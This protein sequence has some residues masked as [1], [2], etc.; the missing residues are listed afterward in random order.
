MSL[1][2]LKASYDDPSLVNEI[3]DSL[4]MEFPDVKVGDVVYY[5]SG[6]FNYQYFIQLTTKYLP[7]GAHFE[8]TTDGSRGSIEF[9]LEAQ[10]EEE[11]FKRLKRIGVR[12]MH[13]LEN[14]PVTCEQ[15]GKLPFGNF[16]VNHGGISNM[17]DFVDKFRELYNI[18]EPRIKEIDKKI[19]EVILQGI[20]PKCD[21]PMQSPVKND[22]EVTSEIMPLKKVMGLRLWLPD[23]QRDYCWEERNITDLWENLLN[24]QKD[25][26]FHLGTL[27]LQANT[28]KGVYDIID[29]QQRLVTLSLILWGL[30]YEGNLPLL[31]AEYSLPESI[32]NIGNSKFIIKSLIERLENR[33]DLL[34]NILSDVSFAVLVVNELNQLSSM[35]YA[36][37]LE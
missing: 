14:T 15:R 3:R 23:Y 30:G 29:G 2:W 21:V 19:V 33:E 31:S 24:I 11:H 10:P 37:F 32:K 22:K 17:A 36:L 27:I 1:T 20:P 7:K 4:S 25:K 28:E 16:Y 5:D 6:Y 9:H 34:D 18:I 35:Y 8:Y 13:T 26:P 12:L